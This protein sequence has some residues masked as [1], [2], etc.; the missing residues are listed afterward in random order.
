MNFRFTKAAIFQMASLLAPLCAKMD[1]RYRKVVPMYVRIACALYKFVHGASLLICLEQFAIGKSTVSSILQDVIHAINIQFQSELS[2][3]RG[4][5]LTSIMNEF[6]EFCSLP[7]VARA[8]DGTHMHIRKPYVGLEDYF[9]FKTSGYNMK[10]QAVVDR[11]KRFV[12]LVVAIRTTRVCYGDHHCTSMP[13]AALCL[14]LLFQLRDSHRTCWETPGT[15][16][17]NGL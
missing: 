12:D 1:T 6:E 7:G 8:I 9:Y 14:I 3:P 10:V 5:C 16:S 13:K 11:R 17:S 15:P 4:A 2:F